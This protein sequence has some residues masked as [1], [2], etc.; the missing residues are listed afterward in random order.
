[1]NVCL[2]S[3]DLLFLKIC[4]LHFY[5]YLLVLMSIFSSRTTLYEEHTDGYQIRITVIILSI[6]VIDDKLQFG[7]FLF[8]VFSGL[9]KSMNGKLLFTNHQRNYVFLY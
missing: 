2:E 3:Y 6:Q 4:K 5:N 9:L 7:T 8:Q 1:M